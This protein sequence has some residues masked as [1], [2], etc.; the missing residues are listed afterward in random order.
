MSPTRLSQSLFVLAVVVGTVQ[1]QATLSAPAS[2][3]TGTTKSCSKW[4][5]V[6]SGDTCAT[7]EATYKITHQ[8]F[9]SWNPAVSSD[10]ISNFWPNYA[11]CVSGSTSTASSTTKTSTTTSR[12]PTTTSKPASSITRVTSPPGPTFTGTPAN[13]N[14]WHTVQDGDTCATVEQKYFITHAQFIAWNPAVSQDCVSN[15]WTKNSYCVGIDP[16][17]PSTRSST[18]SKA[19][20]TS[21]T[22]SRSSTT[23]WKTTLYTPRYPVTTDTIVQPSIPTEWP[24]TKTQ[25]GQPRYCNDWHLVLPGETC[26][27]IANQHTTWMGLED[28]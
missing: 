18:T 3:Q 16:S 19:S 27:S 20:S 5:V 22:S 28:L 21:L 6:K 24:P 14:N 25:A 4:H 23:S 11:Y 7:L 1:G 26:E 17:L 12:A 15:F 13:C 8:Q 2:T 9:L 10:C